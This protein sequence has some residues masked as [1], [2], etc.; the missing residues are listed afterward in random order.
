MA[1]ATQTSEELWTFVSAILHNEPRRLV[2]HLKIIDSV[3]INAIVEPERYGPESFESRLI[4]S[5][6]KDGKVAKGSWTNLAIDKILTL[7]WRKYGTHAPRFAANIRVW[8]SRLGLHVAEEVDYLLL[9]ALEPASAIFGDM[10][11]PQLVPSTRLQTVVK[12]GSFFLPNTR[13]V[14]HKIGRASC[15]ERV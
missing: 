12:A 6:A 9:R 5:Y 15:R 10:P 14:V 1:G 4:N 7:C 2:L 11:I 3:F 8:S 13:H